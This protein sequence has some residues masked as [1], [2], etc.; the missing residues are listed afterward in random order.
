ME[1]KSK[2]SAK[3][4][5]KVGSDNTKRAP[6]EEDTK[7]EDETLLNSQEASQPKEVSLG[8]EVA[9]TV[10]QWS[11]IFKIIILILISLLAFGVRVFSVIRFESV[12][13]EFDPWFNYRT[14]KYLAQNGIY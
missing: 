5:A 2:K 7:V 10:R 6:E 8:N 3:N 13:H 14:T 4:S 11:T 9:A 12:I 1:R